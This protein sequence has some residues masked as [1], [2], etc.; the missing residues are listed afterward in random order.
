VNDKS[1]SFSN[2]ISGKLFGVIPAGWPGTGSRGPSVNASLLDRQGG[3][4]LQQSERRIDSPFLPETR[5]A[6]GERKSSSKPRSRDNG[7]IAFGKAQVNMQHSMVFLTVALILAPSLP[8]KAD[9]DSAALDQASARF[10]A[11]LS[12]YPVHG[13]ATDRLRGQDDTL[14]ALAAYQDQ[15]L[16]CGILVKFEYCSTDTVDDEW[17]HTAALE[18]LLADKE[19]EAHAGISYG[20]DA[21]A[22]RRQLDELR[23]FC[24]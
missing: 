15:A 10:D 1:G 4:F 19:Q 6:D 9:C 18:Q 22:V 23:V 14:T 12:A 2:E 13:T 16:G 7:P 3:N 24:K 8:A 11:A 20:A 17:P 5:F 21:A